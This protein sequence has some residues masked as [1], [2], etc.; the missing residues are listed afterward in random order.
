MNLK[1]GAVQRVAQWFKALTKQAF[2]NDAFRITGQFDK[3]AE[4][5]R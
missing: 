5:T 1:A 4:F 3:Q 2:R